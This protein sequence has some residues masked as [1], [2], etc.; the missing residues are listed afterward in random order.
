ME[1]RAYY[2]K[3]IIP[4]Y[5]EEIESG[6]KFSPE[7]YPVLVYDITETKF[8]KEVIKGLKE[9]NVKMVV[10]VKNDTFQSMPVDIEK[11]DI[12]WIFGKRRNIESIE[13]KITDQKFANIVA[14]NN[15][16]FERYAERVLVL[17]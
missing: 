5:A 10:K 7:K 9:V 13:L 2:Q 12:L 14:R 3:H 17:T 4:E 8:G 15:E 11:R 1:I 6:L 16:L